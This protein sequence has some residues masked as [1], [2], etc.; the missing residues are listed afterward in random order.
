[1]VMRYVYLSDKHIDDAMEA[2]DTGSI[3]NITPKLHAHLKAVS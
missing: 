3:C 2:I 1:M